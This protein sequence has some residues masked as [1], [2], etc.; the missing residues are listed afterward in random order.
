M[1]WFLWRLRWVVLLGSLALAAGLFAFAGHNV[2]DPANHSI[3]RAWLD[4][5]R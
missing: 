1:I 3:L 4:G 5:V 2:A